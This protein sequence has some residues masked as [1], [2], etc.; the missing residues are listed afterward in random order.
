MRL[1]VL[2]L[3]VAACGGGSK[4]LHLPVFASALESSTVVDTT[5][6]VK[7]DVEQEYGT[8]HSVTVE[9]RRYHRKVLELEGSLVVRV[10]ARYEID[11]KVE[12]SGDM[13]P[14]TTDGPLAG[15]AYVLWRDRDALEAEHA[16]GSPITADERVELNAEFD[17][18]G[19]TSRLERFITGRTWK[20]DEV[21][22]LDPDVLPEIGREVAEADVREATMTWLGTEGDRTTLRVLLALTTADG[23]DLQATNDLTFERRT[24]RTVATR[25]TGIIR[26]KVGP[27][28]IVQTIEHVQTTEPE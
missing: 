13:N 4:A 20:P 7:A 5:T 19:T 11:Q 22:P 10:A 25:G 9:H 21:V 3:A 23:Y 28:E 16:D 1:A 18:L 26:A 8:L 2:L 17:D 12:T 27:Y 14:I 15:K 6:T 24:G